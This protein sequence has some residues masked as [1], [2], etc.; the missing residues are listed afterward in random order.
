[1][2]RTINPKRRRGARPHSWL[3][4][5]RCG[6]R[7]HPLAERALMTSLPIGVGPACPLVAGPVID[8]RE[9]VVLHGAA[10]QDRLELGE[11]LSR[12]AVWRASPKATVV[13]GPRAFPSGGVDRGPVRLHD[14]AEAGQASGPDG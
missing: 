9:P 11:E 6:A 4:D 8:G 3:G 1:M 12:T 2:R 7:D 13:S 10:G 5:R 14:L